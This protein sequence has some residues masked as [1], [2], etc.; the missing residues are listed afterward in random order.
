MPQGIS[1][2][3]LILQLTG[4]FNR[5]LQARLHYGDPGANGTANGLAAVHGYAHVTLA[6]NA[7]TREGTTGARFSNAA[8][9]EW[10]DANGGAWGSSATEPK[11]VAWLTLWYDASDVDNTVTGNFDTLLA[12]FQ[13]RTPR[14]VNDGDSFIIEAREMDVVSS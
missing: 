2:T 11:D 1:E 6:K 3:G 9:I 4:I 10:P 8:N 14:R 5:T 12:T 7:F 13:M